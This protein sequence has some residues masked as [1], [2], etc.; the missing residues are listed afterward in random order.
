MSAMTW[1]LE[2]LHVNDAQAQTSLGPRYWKVES[3]VS[4]G[5]TP[6]QMSMS[7]PDGDFFG[8]KNHISNGHQ[9]A[10]EP[11][12]VA[13]FHHPEKWWSSSMGRMTSHIWNG[14]SSIHVPVTTNQ[15]LLPII[16]HHYPIINQINGHLKP[17][18]PKEYTTVSAMVF[19]ASSTI[20]QRF[21]HP[22]APL[23]EAGSAAGPLRHL[24]SGFWQPWVHLTTPYPGSFP[25]L[26]DVY[27]Y[28]LYNIIY[29][30]ILFNII[31]I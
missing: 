3:F 19:A 2:F 27:I 24:T 5:Q 1:L 25:F 11:Q 7:R 18:F 17:S 26:L 21:F 30:Y 31:Y 8:I 23:P 14:K 12:L 28:I 15:W 6:Q 13:G 16:N 22:P 20:S 9:V 29:I 4:T 10:I